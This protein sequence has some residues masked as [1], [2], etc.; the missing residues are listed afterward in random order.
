MKQSNPKPTD[1]YSPRN[2]ENFLREN[3]A[4]NQTMRY[5]LTN[6]IAGVREQA[7]QQGRRD[8]LNGRSISKSVITEDVVMQSE[9]A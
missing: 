4:G 1:H 6:I 7:Y 9:T 2:V 5:R 3:F 8:A